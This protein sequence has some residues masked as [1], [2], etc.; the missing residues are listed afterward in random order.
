MDVPPPPEGKISTDSDEKKSGQL[1]LFFVVF[2]LNFCLTTYRRSG[3]AHDHR[4]VGR[5]RRAQRARF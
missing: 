5:V 2:F 4:Q 1:V 3:I